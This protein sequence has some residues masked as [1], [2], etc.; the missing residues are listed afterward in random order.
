MG[1]EEEILADIKRQ[2]IAE[3]IELGVS[4]GLELGI[5]EGL[6]HGQKQIIKHLLKK[7]ISVKEI[8][9]I[10]DYSIGFILKTKEDIL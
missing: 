7:K 9:E 3:G 10:T 8:Q 4:K 1:L 5:S 6:E 2:G